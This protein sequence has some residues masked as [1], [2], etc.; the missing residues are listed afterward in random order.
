MQKSQMECDNCL[1]T[2]ACNELAFT[3]RD[4]KT[5]L[6]ITLCAD[7]LN[8]SPEMK[9]YIKKKFPE[10]EKGVNKMYEPGSSRPN[11]FCPLAG[12]MDRCKKKDCMFWDP[13]MNYKKAVGGCMVVKAV[14]DLGE[15]RDKIK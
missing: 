14:R 3:I 2:I 13:D 15:I 10:W 12:R 5:K 7:C 9:A 11:L 8:V 4:T 6:E 1:R